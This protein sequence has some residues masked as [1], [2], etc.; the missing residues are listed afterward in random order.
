M[1]DNHLINEYRSIPVRLVSSLALFDLLFK[2]A[3]EPQACFEE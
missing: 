1:A 3:R 2:G